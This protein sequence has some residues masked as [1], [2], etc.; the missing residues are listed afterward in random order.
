[1]TEAA[2]ANRNAIT[3]AKKGTVATHAHERR[4]RPDTRSGRSAGDAVWLEIG[5]PPT[6]VGHC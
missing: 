3:Y 6:F 2:G 5:Y 1:M 4:F